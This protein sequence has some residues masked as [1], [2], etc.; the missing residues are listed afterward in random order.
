MK[1]SSHTSTHLFSNSYHSKYRFGIADNG[2]IYSKNSQPTQDIFC[3]RLA[4]LYNSKSV[5]SCKTQTIINSMVSA[6]ASGNEKIA[7]NTALFPPLH[8]AILTACDKL[9]V[10]IV[11]FN[12]NTTLTDTIQ[13]GVKA[14]ILSCVSVDC[15]YAN[16]HQ[17]K[18][19]CKEYHTPLIIDNTLATVFSCNPLSQGADIVLEM[20]QLVSVGDEKDHYTTIIERDSFEWLKSNGYSKL[21]PYRNS[22]YPFT[23]YLRAKCRKTNE[24]QNKETQA[25]YYML[26]EGLRTLYDRF[27]LH[28]KNSYLLI[29]LLQRYSHSISYNYYNNKS[30]IFITANLLPE[31]TQLLKD[32]LINSTVQNKD[33]LCTMFNCTSVFFNNNTIHIKIGT[34]PYSYLRLLFSV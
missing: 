16:I 21:Y 7:I 23:A 26:C 20:S 30:P 32:K 19:L 28:T 1:K 2:N 4:R 31:Y 6:L 9:S 34:E 8:K 10:K 18:K 29:K 22:S 5:I 12:D 14:V 3:R 25:D 15:C 11:Y 27:N 33:Q 13:Q 24:N 17:V